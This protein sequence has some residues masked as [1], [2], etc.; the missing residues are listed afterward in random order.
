MYRKIIIENKKY[1]I[2]TFLFIIFFG[3]VLY[4][5][6]NKLYD[7]ESKW[8][9]ETGTALMKMGKVAIESEFKN[10]AHH[11]SFL[12][13]IPSVKRFVDSEFT[14]TENRIET[15]RILYNF[16]MITNEIYEVSL[17]NNSGLELIKIVSGK[18]GSKRSISFS[19]LYAR[20]DQYHIK[21][22]INK[23]ITNNTQKM[24]SSFDLN[25]NDN[26]NIPVVHLY[27]SMVGDKGTKLG[28]M[29]LTANLEKIL[30]LLPNDTFV[31]TADGY[32]VMLSSKGL[33]AVEK[34]KYQ[35]DHP[36]GK[37][38]V[39][40]TDNI[41]YSTIKLSGG[42]K[43]IVG[44]HHSHIGLRAGLQKI[45]LFSVFF[46]LVFIGFVWL[47]SYYN[48]SRFKDKSRAQKALISALVELT[49]W[50]DH[51]TGDHLL[52]TKLISKELSIQ[53]RKQ[54]KFKKQI[55]EGFINDI[56]D[57]SPLHD[58][59]KV[60]IKDSILLKPGRLTAD[61]YEEMKHHVIIGKQII[62][63]VIDKFKINEPFI[64]MARNICW[65]HHEKYN[66]TGYPQKLKAD[67]IPLEARIFSLADVYDALRSK[68]PYKNEMTH[69]EVTEEIYSESGEHF[70]PE[71]VDA[72]IKIEDKIEKIF[73]SYL[74]KQK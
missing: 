71:I 37:I 16:A 9:D 36:D 23:E 31:Q 63:D 73:D 70:D 60:G 7:R 48:I 18:S 61:E 4:Y 32:I 15:D 39:S 1:F 52:R 21:N 35:F 40:K 72:F 25:F 28:Y 14:S 43:M 62:Q 3:V 68:R 46:S 38:V 58:I 55:T 65:A 47:I 50:R 69:S 19:E 49:D 56:F 20:N 26:M 66:G 6:T 33:A 42:N 29:V 2:I 11:L 8:R 13:N 24:G 74:L 53:L 51:E 44:L 27:I 45:I 12:S 17:I 67:E 41:H 57:T 30:Q 59:G 64:V 22:T 10:L 5:W 54:E 34:A